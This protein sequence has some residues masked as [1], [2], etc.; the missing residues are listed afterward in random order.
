[1]N[2][3][4]VNTPGE[5]VSSVE[6]EIVAQNP[7]TQN[8]F[9]LNSIAAL[10]RAGLCPRLST[11]LRL[12]L[13]MLLV[14][15]SFTPAS[16]QEG[17]EKKSSRKA[18]AYYA[19]AAG[20][21]NNGAYELAIEEWQKLLKEFPKDPL[22]SKAAHYL[23]V[24]FIQLETPNY[25]A[26]IDAFSLA[27]KDKELEVREESQI[28]LCWCEFNRAREAE[29]GSREQ[30]AGFVQAKK[31]LGEFMQKYEKGSYRDQALFYLGEIEY[32]LGDTQ[33]SIS[34][35]RQ[36]LET[37]GL[38][39]SNLR[40]DAMYAL[41]VAYEEQGSAAQARKQYESFLAEH[42]KHRLTGEVSVRLADLLLADGKPE[43][44]EKLLQ[45]LASDKGNRMA[46]YALLRLGYSLARQGKPEL[47]AEQYRKLLE[48]FPDSEH[49][50]VASLSV[51]Q[52]SYESGQYDDALVQFRSVLDGKDTQAAE[53][54]HWMSMTLMRQNKPAEVVELLESALKWADKSPNAVALQMDYAD[55]LY[56]LPDQI[57]KAKAAYEMIA[58]EYPDDALAPRAAYNAAFAALQSG[59]FADARKWSEFFLGRYPQDVLRND[60]AYVAAEALLQEGEHEAAAKAYSKLRTVD[61]KNQAYPLWTLRLATSY[62]LAGDYDEAVKLLSSEMKII[63]QP[64]QQAEAQFV[65]GASL[66]YQEKTKEAIDQLKLSHQTNAQWGSADEVLL[67]LAEAHQRNQD[68]ESAKQ[69]LE[70]LL[71][72]Y[73]N[74]RLKAQVDYKLAQLSAAMNE[75]D[76]A[77][78][79]YGKIVADPSASSYHRF[80]QYG[81][82]WCH[83]QNEDYQPALEQL[84][85]LLAQ[86]STDSIAVEA[87]LAEGICLSKLGR[88]R[89][90]IV[91]L[92]KF[93]GM[94]PSGKSLA[95]GLYELGL[96]YTDEG[97]LSEATAQFERILSE[98]PTYP[99]LDKVLYELAWNEQESGGET[100]AGE[101]F[102]RLAKEFPDSNYS[103]EAMY[104]LAQQKYEREDYAAAAVSY[105]ALMKLTQ[106]PGLLEKS[107]YKL[108]WSWFQ[109]ED[110]EQAAQEFSKQA[111]SYADGSLVVDA[112]FMNAE[113]DFKREQ[114]DAALEG[115]QAAKGVLEKSPEKTAAS[116]QVKTLIYLHGAQ[117]FRELKR[118]P[119]CEQWLSVVVDR[120]PQS[121]YIATA[122]YE[123]GYCKQ[124]QGEVEQALAH[125]AEVANNYRNEIG[126]RSRFMMGEV[127]FAERDFVKAIPEFQRVM[128]GFGGDKAPAEI[129]NWQVKSAYEAA[130]CS[131]VLIENLRGEGR[132]KVVA[133]AQ[134]FYRFITE[135]HGAHELAAQAKSRLGELQ[136]LR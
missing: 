110:Y 80:A 6:P 125:Y 129:K 111:K 119:E 58:K 81:I 117:C 42:E 126:A 86:R 72:K 103:P 78:E 67:M 37:R 94:S 92:E 65:L 36:L 35:Y 46:D 64:A 75:L 40:P 63:K 61:A 108:G 91:S 114:Y 13:L 12:A 79:Q 57:E 95:G 105:Q 88:S 74:T 97:K 106:D 23:G 69:T 82:V 130:R 101:Y 66:L 7:F 120:Y 2:R 52:A 41:A 39:K 84:A 53:A 128:Y 21:Q 54:V 89:E 45:G 51:G 87:Q 30:R 29:L 15:F 25:G 3:W 43:Q 60:V 18:T 48:L 4:L 124:Q 73:P 38:E 59:K 44:A 16:A 26:A 62:Y 109:Q 118:W 115:Y 9:A 136:K 28:N 123:L 56:A 70:M 135:N 10:V 132:E 49:A 131:E 121:P 22:A 85:P 68:N 102:G 11:G 77:L 122:L 31:L 24:C 133:A 107:Q 90:A 50:R 1:M 113:C 71:E 112:L 47:A 34:Y 116:E 93:L 5:F 100:K 76:R 98:V 83:M 134:D 27:L 17:G 14:G 55:A 8:H 19:D 127:Y 20:Y 32:S 104:M 96:A 99:A 33:K